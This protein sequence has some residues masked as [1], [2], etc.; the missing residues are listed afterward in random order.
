MSDTE[1]TH[2]QIFGDDSDDDEQPQQ[3]NQGEYI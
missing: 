2:E 1:P 3:A